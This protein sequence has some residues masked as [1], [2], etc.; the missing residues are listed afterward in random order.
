MALLLPGEKSNSLSRSK[1]PL[2]LK[3]DKD[4]F[5]VLNEMVESLLHSEYP[6]A[7]E[8]GQLQSLLKSEVA[9]NSDL[10]L[11]IQINNSEVLTRQ[12]SLP[13][14]TEE[15]LYE[16]IQYEMDRYTPFKKDDV[17][18]DYRIEERI[19]EKQLI[20]VLL[21][22]IR[23]EVL[24]PVVE[25]IKNTGVHLQSIDVVS[26][27]DSN[28]DVLDVKLLRSYADI[29]KRNSSSTKWLFG[30]VAGLLL[31]TGLTPLIINYIHIR[32]LSSELEG[33]ESTVRKVK[34]LQSEYSK[35]QDQ[36]GYLVKIKERHP[37]I[38][39]LLNLLTTVLPDH[40]HVERLSVEDGLLSIQGLSASAADLI[41]IIDQSGLFD[42]IRFSA[43][44]TQSGADG[45]ERYSITAQIK[46]Q[47]ES[48][49]TG[50]S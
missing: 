39:E 41:P 40:T 49:E 1:R 33:L 27:D 43:P 36:V 12:I 6:I 29:G 45:L 46:A 5:E 14:T 48:P 25:A 44:V 26:A 35:M 9:K 13:A 28:Q 16:V 32:K 47:I 30:A 4:N 23:K 15:N 31:L 21:I 20:K 8:E 34:L 42:D 10:E 17:Y 50:K 19:P 11:A 7:N 2:L 37:S 24:A 18:F 38:I 3:I 22:V